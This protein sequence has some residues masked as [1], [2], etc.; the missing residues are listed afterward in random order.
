MAETGSLRGT[1]HCLET[2]TILKNQAGMEVRQR[3]KNKLF[4]IIFLL[5]LPLGI[6][7]A[8]GAERIALKAD[9]TTNVMPIRWD[10][11]Y[12]RIITHPDKEKLL[13]G[14]ILC[15]IKR[16]DART[17]VAQSIGLIKAKAEECFKVIRNY[18]QY[19]QVMPCTVENKVVRSFQL[20]GEYSGV[21]AVDFWT[22]V[23]VLG[24]DTAYLLRI[25]HLSDIKKHLF[26]SF[27]TLVDNPAEMAGCQDTEKKPCQNDL[28][29][30][31]GAHQF[32]P[33][34]GNSNYTLH[35]YTLTVSGKTWLQQMAFNLG[36]KKSMGDVTACIRNAVEKKN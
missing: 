36:G 8:F 14:E 20:E 5:S 22:R 6:L 25:A 7:S 1:S 35:T 3:L 18:N 19:I 23:R 2:G 24:F 27:W 10:Q 11:A 21:E 34:P 31:L 17:V 30:N 16:V 32:E 33:F 13:Q 28:A 9:G 4:F 26:R 29:V 15:E 12:Q